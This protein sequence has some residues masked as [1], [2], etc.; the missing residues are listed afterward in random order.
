M[1]HESHVVR[2]LDHSLDV[3]ASQNITRSIRW[4]LGGPKPGFPGKVLG[5]WSRP[6]WSRLEYLEMGKIPKLMSWYLALQFVCCCQK[7]TSWKGRVTRSVFFSVSRISEIFHSPKRVSRLPWI[8]TKSKS[9]LRFQG[10]RVT[11]GS[12]KVSSRLPWILTKSKSSLRF[13]GF[14]VTRGTFRVFLD[15]QKVPRNLK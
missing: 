12:F 6:P 10:F 14:R 4:P 13:Q 7:E 11:R 3:T 8:L 1:C 2:H 9:S 15:S 5:S